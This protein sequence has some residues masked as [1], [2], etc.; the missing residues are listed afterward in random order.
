MC[1]LCL[2]YSFPLWLKFVPG[3]RAISVSSW[4]EYSLGHMRWFGRM[5]DISQLASKV[6]GGESRERGS[7]AL[8]STYH[9]LSGLGRGAGRG[10]A[11]PSLGRPHRRKKRLRCH[12]PVTGTCCKQKSASVFGSDYHLKHFF[13][14]K[15]TV[16][17]SWCSAHLNPNTLTHN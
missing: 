11:F 2:M 10:V 16:F 6:G 4:Q 13:P 9:S 12:I 14:L 5:S 15:L 3:W 1:V 7:G 17:K 8:R